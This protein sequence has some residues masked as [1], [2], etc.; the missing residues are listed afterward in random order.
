MEGVFD[1]MKNKTVDMTNGS[2]MKGL[3]AL[4]MPIMIMNVAQSLFNLLDIWV[5]KVFGFESAVGAIGACG[6]LITLCTCLLIGISAGANVVTARHV[7]AKEKK[8]AES[9]IM[10]AIA[11]SI[12]GGVLLMILGSI[13]AKTFL[14]LTNCHVSLLSDAT[15]YFKLYFLASPAIM[16]YNFAASL[17]RALGDS[18]KP[19]YFLFVCCICKILLTVLLISILRKP[20][21]SV[22]IATIVSNVISSA[23]ALIA[24]LKNKVV[25]NLSI[26]RLRIDFK[27][28]KAILY[29]GVPA[30]LQSAMYAL[31]NVII[32]SV[33]NTFG[34]DATTGISIANQFDGIMY[35]VS[36]AP[37]LATV[38]FVAQN[39]GAG[40]LDRAKKTLWCGIFIS[41]AF[42]ATL[43]SLSAIFSRQLS[44]LMSS[45]EAVVSFSVQKMIIVSSTY[46]ICGINEVLGGTLKG[47][48]KPVAP[49]VTSLLYM[50]VL[51]F[52]W[53]YFIFP[54]N[55]N[56]TFLYLVWPIG[57][58]LSIITLSIIYIHTIFKYKTTLLKG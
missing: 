43:G 54:H 3:T 6:M 30:G 35:Q 19:M 58:V 21:E 16:V 13:F 31:A 28:L 29:N 23:L 39:I 14:V 36:Y 25:A 42:G 2:I 55:P 48:G 38:P 50:C 11:F 17:L 37:S 20:I 51:R 41:T 22:G 33:V 8:L 40:R 44:F 7:G 26:K 5:V 9:S 27:E 47:M 10:T 18:K 57:W 56:L 1:G 24:L 53:V 15:L 34:P 32:T 12:I 45:S 4:T 49:A 46:F 52:I